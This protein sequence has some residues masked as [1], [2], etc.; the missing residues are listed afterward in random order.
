[1]AAKCKVVFRRSG[2]GP[3][4]ILLWNG[5]SLNAINYPRGARITVT[6][7]RRAKAKLMA[8]C[9]ELVRDYRR[10]ARRR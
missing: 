3:A 1:M 2:V 7:A 6:E 9:A 4:A 10:H 8:G 5:R